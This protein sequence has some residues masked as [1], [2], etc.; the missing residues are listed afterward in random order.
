MPP[1][2]SGRRLCLLMEAGDTR[3]SVEATSVMEVAAPGPDETSL[4][5]V[6]EVTD[7][8][9]LLGGSPEQ[10]PGMVVVFDVSPTLAVRVRSIVEVVDVASAPHFLLPS[11]LGDT[12]AALSR[13]AVLHKDRLYLELN[14]EALPH[15]PGT[16][17]PPPE[18]PV[19]F[20]GSPPE[21]SLVFESQGRLFGLPLTLISQV[22]MRGPA[23]SAL[24]GKS[25]AVAGVM[26][27]GQAL[28]PLYSAPAL[29]GGASACAESFL[30]LAE[31]EGRGLGL[32]AS[33]VL[34]VHPRFEPAGEPGEFT[35]PG[36]Q[37]PV[38]FLDLRR[39]FS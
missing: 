22:V 33:R 28:W 26:P 16:V 21:R 38:L 37:A 27:H 39:M 36:L 13:S 19:H 18:H 1:Y 35:A 30:V 24:P 12:L 5:G 8:S 4:R 6:L 34:G 29:L 7:L 9:V 17:S 25:G 15:E 31:V 32:C 20:A 11:G 23:F 3:F 14:P 10:G 2:E